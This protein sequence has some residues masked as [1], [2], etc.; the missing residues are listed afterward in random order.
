MPHLILIPLQY[1]D[2][3]FRPSRPGACL[4][5]ISILS[6]AVRHVDI[7]SSPWARTAMRFT[8]SSP[9]LTTAEFSASARIGSLWSLPSGT[10]PGS[11]FR[12]TTTLGLSCSFSQRQSFKL[13]WF[14]SLVLMKLAQFL[15][16]EWWQNRGSWSSLA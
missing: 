10:R 11:R 8:R 9:P 2:V 12:G 7:P 14:P 16:P 13:S 15:I 3:Q 1:I 6:R 5:G 4:S